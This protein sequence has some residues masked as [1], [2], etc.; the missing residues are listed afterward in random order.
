VN[1]VDP[2]GTG[3]RSD[4]GYDNDQGREDVQQTTYH[5]EK[6][7]QEDQKYERAIGVSPE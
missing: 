1:G 6:E 4:E 5:Q 3:N 7:V 2:I